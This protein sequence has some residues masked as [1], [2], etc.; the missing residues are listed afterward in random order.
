M[1]QHNLLGGLQISVPKVHTLLARFH[2]GKRYLRSM[3][4]SVPDASTAGLQEDV[5]VGDHQIH[6]RSYWRDALALESRTFA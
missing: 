3:Y 4:C 2:H 1:N 6:S 5:P